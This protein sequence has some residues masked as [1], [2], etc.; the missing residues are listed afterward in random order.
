M[1]RGACASWHMASGAW[2]ATLLWAL[3]W[4]VAATVAAPAPGPLT[5][6]ARVLYVQG[7]LEEA[8]SRLEAALAGAPDYLPAH[9]LAAVVWQARGQPARALE[10]YWAVQRSSF[11]PLSA[12]APEDQVRERALLVHAESLLA[13]LANAERLS[14]KLPLLLPDPRLAVIARQHS[15]EMRDLGYFS[16][17]SPTPGYKTIKARFI[18]RFPDLASFAIG[19][20]IARRYAEGAFS[21]TVDAVHRTHQEWMDS[22]GHRRNILE[23]KFSHLGVGVACKANGDYW[24]TQFFARLPQ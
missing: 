10:H 12:E 5:D 14:R 9:Q 17:E 19:E 16:H 20:N 13:L 1:S 24:A 2:T 22:P 3:V 23:S 18:R 21:L 11:D 6:E 7:R 4:Q 8:T 15:E